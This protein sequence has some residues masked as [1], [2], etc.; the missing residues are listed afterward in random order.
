METILMMIATINKAMATP[1]E[2][3]K[4]DINPIFSISESFSV[5]LLYQTRGWLLVA[6]SFFEALRQTGEQPAFYLQNVPSKEN[7]LC[8]LRYNDFMPQILRLV[9]LAEIG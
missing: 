9:R 2:M 6:V 5:F 1:E 3:L 8:Q 4:F 7:Q